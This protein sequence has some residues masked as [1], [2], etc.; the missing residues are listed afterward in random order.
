MSVFLF[1]LFMQV[2]SEI[3]NRSSVFDLHNFSLI[4]SQLRTLCLRNISHQNPCA[5]RLWLF[6]RTLNLIHLGKILFLRVINQSSW[7]LLMGF[8]WWRNW[9]IFLS[10]F[11]N[12]FTVT[13]EHEHHKTDEFLKHVNEVWKYVRCFITYYENE[14]SK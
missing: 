8:L 6:A 12:F 7:D 5:W 11:C 4:N 1:I 3:F 10:S 2:I 14:Q 13:L 9:K